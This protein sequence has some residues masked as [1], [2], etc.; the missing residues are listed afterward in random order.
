MATGAYGETGQAAPRPVEE[1]PTLEQDTVIVLHQI[2]AAQI[3][4]A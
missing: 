2:L 1:E 4:Q 3:A